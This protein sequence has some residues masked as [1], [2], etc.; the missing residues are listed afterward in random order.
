SATHFAN[1]TLAG[2]GMTTLWCPSSPDA[3]LS[4]DLSA[5]IPGGTYGTS[6]NSVLG[7]LLPPGHWYQR[8]AC[9]TACTGL[10][11]VDDGAMVASAKIS[12]LASITDGTSN[13]MLLSEW[14]SAW[15]SQNSQFSPSERPPWNLGGSTNY[16]TGW[17]P[18]NPQ[19]WCTTSSLFAQ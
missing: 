16:F 10:I 7:Y 9:Y 17:H 2:V 18:P 1:I 19:R 11:G 12:R 13:T 14:T 8:F 5:G 6:Y 3:Q 4:Y 15:V